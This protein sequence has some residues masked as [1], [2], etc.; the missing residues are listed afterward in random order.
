MG[1]LFI[2]VKISPMCE[3]RRL[4]PNSELQRP[5]AKCRHRWK[6]NIV[7][8]LNRRK[9]THEAENFTEVGPYNVS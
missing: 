2:F 6:D 3:V 5:L 9:M 1:W 7:V 8:K 4:V